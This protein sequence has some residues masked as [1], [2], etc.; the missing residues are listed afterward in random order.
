MKA[1]LR[2]F[3][4]MA[5]D[6]VHAVSTLISATSKVADVA[7]LYAT[8]FKETTV[9]ELAAEQAIRTKQLAELAD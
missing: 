2:E 8:D 3:F 7:D 9:K 6:A 1:F 4:S 5:T